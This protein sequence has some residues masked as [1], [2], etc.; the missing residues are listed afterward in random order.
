MMDNNTTGK[1]IAKV[2]KVSQKE[3]EG[4]LW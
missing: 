2:I 3:A 1:D 4:I